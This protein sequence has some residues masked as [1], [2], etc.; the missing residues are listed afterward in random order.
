MVGSTGGPPPDHL[1]AVIKGRNF[2]QE[3]KR[4]DMSEFPA[5]GSRYNAQTLL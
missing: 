4:P 1:A 5:L 2:Q 3:A